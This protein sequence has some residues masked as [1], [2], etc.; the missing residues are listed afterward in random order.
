MKLLPVGRNDGA[1]TMSVPMAPYK[2]ILGTLKLTRNKHKISERERGREGGRERERE[3]ERERNNSAVTASF[4]RNSK[5]KSNETSARR[6]KSQTKRTR[7]ASNTSS[8]HSPKKSSPGGS[9][10]LARPLADNINLSGIPREWNREFPGGTRP[11]TTARPTQ[12]RR[13]PAEPVPQSRR[14]TSRSGNAAA[15]PTRNKNLKIQKGGRGRW[16]A[17]A[18]RGSQA[19]RQQRAGRKGGTWHRGRSIRGARVWA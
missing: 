10:T 19:G 17:A 11:A 8:N 18:E 14:G 13:N 12:T 15:N 7:E 9:K 2:N 5:S 1:S 6:L 3:R 16:G 4:G